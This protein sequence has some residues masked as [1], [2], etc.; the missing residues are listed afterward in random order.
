MVEAPENSQENPL[1]E[2][3]GGGGAQPR[4]GFREAVAER[5]GRL[6]PLSCAGG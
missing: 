4:V 6:G 3:G 5:D 2:D 1:P